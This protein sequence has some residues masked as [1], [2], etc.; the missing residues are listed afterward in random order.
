MFG[1]GWEGADVSRNWSTYKS[2]QQ[3]AGFAGFCHCFGYLTQRLTMFKWPAWIFVD[4]YYFS[5]IRKLNY[6]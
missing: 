6:E 2:R 5:R 1:D 3:I 4:E